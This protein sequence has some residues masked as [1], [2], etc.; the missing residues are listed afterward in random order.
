VNSFQKPGTYLKESH[1]VSDCGLIY[2]KVRGLSAECQEIGF[3]RN[4][5]ADGKPVDQVHSSWT[6]GAFSSPW[7]GAMADLGSSLELS[8]QPLWGSRSPRKGRGRWR[9]RRRAHL[10]AH[11]KYPVLRKRERSLHTCAQDVQ[12]TRIL[13]I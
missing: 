11:L 8:L 2:N 3:S 12:I 4:Y 9:R 7:T 1:K 5:F 13:T 10:W 6:T